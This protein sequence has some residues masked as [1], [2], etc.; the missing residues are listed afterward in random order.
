MRTLQSSSGRGPYSA[1]YVE[2]AARRYPMTRTILEKYPGCPVIPVRRYKDVFSR[3]R[4]SLRRQKDFPALI[5][6]VK[7]PPFLYPGPDVCQD[8][9]ADRFFYTSFLLNCPFSCDYCY[10]QGMYPS[11]NLVAFVNIEDFRDAIEA[12][13]RQAPDA[14]TLIAASYDTDLMAFDPVFP[15]LEK[16][17]PFL[18][19]RKNL[20]V[21]VRTKSAGLSFFRNH[22]PID[23]VVVAF[24]LAPDAVIRKYEK[25]TPPLDARL[26]AVGA[27][28]GAGFRVRLCFDPVFIEPALDKEYEPF[29]R[30]VFSRVDPEKILDA[31]HGFFRMNETFFRRVQRQRP[32]TPLCLADF[33]REGDIVTYGEEL[34]AAVREKHLAVLSEYIPKERIFTT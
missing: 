27:A 24:T 21:E 23:S 29:F 28:V 18:R 20:S 7:E 32:D 12:Q 34:R 10:L 26:A 1:I 3:P 2:E 13:L 19:A 22:E 16:L 25:R 9:G 14:H 4:Q 6:A 8:F 30:Y 11:A 17:Y 33:G 15:Y 5:L 31:S